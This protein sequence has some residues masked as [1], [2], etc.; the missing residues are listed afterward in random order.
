[1]PPS[2]IRAIQLNARTIGGDY[3]GTYPYLPLFAALAAAMVW[4]IVRLFRR[5]GTT[6]ILQFS[7]IF[8][9][10]MGGITLA[11][12]WGGVSIVPQPHRYQI[13]MEMAF[14]LAGV[15]AV[16]PLVQRAP[17][18]G[19]ALAACVFL[20]AC[21]MQLW[22]Y[23]VFA[24]NWIRPGDIT[25]TIEYKTAK[26]FDE[27]M[28]GRRVLAPGST[29]FWLNNFTDTPQLGGGFDQGVTNPVNRMA[30][31][32]VFAS[33]DANA[34]VIWLKAF[35]VHAIAVGGPSSGEFWRPFR[36]PEIYAGALEKAWSEG[37][38]AIY[39]VPQRSASLAHAV[40][41]EELVREEPAGGEDGEPLRAYVAALDD[42]SRPVADL[43]WR[44]RHSAEITASLEPDRLL[45]VQIAYHPG[46]SAAVNGSPRRVFADGIGQIAIEP[47]CAGACNV[48]LFYDGGIEALIARWLSILGLAGCLAWAAAARFARS[49]N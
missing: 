48:E 17:R 24:G 40:S 23:R 34:A 8:S 15:F 19:R 1:M 26:W 36:H 11:W 7:V 3:T 21:G 37:D 46:W 29:S 43:R 5:P 13:E 4:G 12:A 10:F 42:P 44:N 33:D 39:W 25:E 14:A 47:E 2:N 9:L 30:R 45:S 6:A 20:L 31:D 18:M 22:N 49:N 41:R 35:G 32:F 27:N 16:R 28:A 38:D